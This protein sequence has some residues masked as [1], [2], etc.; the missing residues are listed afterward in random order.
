MLTDS[1]LSLLLSGIQRPARYIGGEVNSVVKDWESVECRLAL[2]FPDIYEIGMSHLG[3]GIL[4]GVV[5]ARPDAAAERVFMPW[6]DMDE[7]MEARGIPLFSL[8]TRRS[9]GEFDIVGFSL[10][11]ELSYPTVLRMLDIS[12]VP[13]RRWQRQSQGGP[14]VIAGGPCAFNPAPLAEFVDIFV[15][16]DGEEAIGELIDVWKEKRRA[17]RPELVAA[18]AR[19]VKGVYAPALGGQQSGGVPVEPACVE[20]L[21]AAFYPTA[22]VVAHVESVHDRISLEVMRGC[23]RG[24][25]FCQAGMTRR[26]VRLRSVR[27]L[28]ELAQASYRNT[29]HSE[30]GLLSLATGDYPHLGELAARLSHIFTPLKV[31]LAY[32]SLRADRALQVIPHSAGEVRKSTITVAVEAGTERLRSVINKDITEGGLL[33]GMRAAFEAGWSRVKLYFMAGLPTETT[34]DVEAI[35]EI[36]ARVVEAGKKA[37]RQPQVGVS[38]APFIPKPGTPFQWNPMAPRQQLEDARETLSQRLRGL[39]VKLSFHN[40]DR[41]IVEAALA[42]GGLE[43]QGALAAA[44]DMGARLDAWDEGFDFA[45]WRRAFDS[46]DLDIEAY[47]GREMEPGRPLPWDDVSAGVSAE[48]LVR[49]HHRA[50]RQESTPDCTRQACQRCGLE[51]GPCAMR[52]RKDAFG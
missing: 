25:R 8:E 38:V 9:L 12:G 42:R 49:E 51:K 37:G 30:I 41:S 3:L 1:E 2:A 4:Y 29:G 32:P 34:E 20:D 5:N 47:A 48:Y 7:R 27:R 17:P 33:D 44:A 52:A 45:R 13:R 19:R 15:T 26:P 46:V 36:V 14:L 43:V 24:C 50:T 21:D 6:F 10:Q 35:A 23:A 16:G 28:V 22:P 31:S 39:P 40:I 11:Y 18:I